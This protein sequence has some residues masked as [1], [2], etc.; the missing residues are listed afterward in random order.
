MVFIKLVKREIKAFLKNPAF[1]ISIV[2][3]LVMFVFIG[4]VTRTSIEQT[5]KLVLT[6]EVG[7]VLEEETEFTK[8][9]ILYLNQ[10]FNGRIKQCSSLVEAVEKYGIGISIPRGFTE[11]ST[12]G[13]PI[14]FLD[15]MFK[16]DSFS[17]RSI[18]AKAALVDGVVKAFESLIP[19]V[20]AQLY[21]V[22][23]PLQ[24]KV[25][26]RY[27]RVLFYGR[28]V[29][30]QILFGL[31]VLGSFIPFILGLVM[32]LNAGYASQLVAYEKVE[33]AFEMLLAQPIKRSRIVAAKIIGASVANIIFGL[34]YFGG[35]FGMI[36]SSMPIQQEQGV[37]IGSVFEDMSRELGFDVG[38]HLAVSFI[39]PLL[40][41]LF[42]SGAMGIILGS[43]S[44]DE[45]TASVLSKPI[46]LVYIAIAMITM[47]IGLE[48]NIYTSILAGF[49]PLILPAIY[50]VSLITGSIINLLIPVALNVLIT[51][52][53][54][55]VAIVIFN[56]DIVILGVKIKIGRR[57]AP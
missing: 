47:Y 33:K 4:S 13:Q 8:T 20:T 6:S 29:S 16:V 51:V 10:S 56:R 25:A 57:E 38:L 28:E 40:L 54:V 35:I 43:L 53:L 19:I 21:G 27:N 24:I 49:V 48:V 46:T 26:T 39:I 37:E 32:G 34:V 36:Y 31:F 30:Q 3:L 22:E 15:A 11:N 18:Q 44:Q 52:L 14:V 41:G 17:Q 2:L 1:I 12:T 55:I 45:R 42:Q 50:L 5:Q 7:V 23:Q 9:L